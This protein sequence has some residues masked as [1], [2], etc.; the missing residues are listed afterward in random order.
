MSGSRGVVAADGTSYDRRMSG[1]ARRMTCLLPRLAKRG[2][3]P[4]LFVSRQTREVFRDL[5]G[6]RVVDLPVPAHPA[7]V[8][9]R[10][11]RAWMPDLVRSL[12]AGI[13]LT[14]IPP[15]PAEIPYLLTVHDLRVWDDPRAVGWGRRMWVLHTLPG[16]L[17][18]AAALATP[19]EAT[20]ARLR[21]RFP[22]CAP[23]VIPNGCDH[24]PA[25]QRRNGR[26]FFL[27]VGPWP[28]RKELGM[29]LAAHA[30]L[31][32]RPPL[33]LVGDPGRSLPAGVSA[34]APDDATL[35]GLYAGAAAT[36]CPSRMEGFG[37]PL[38]EALRL[39]CPVVA[40]DIPPHREVGGAVVRYFPPGAAAVLARQM[41]VVL[42]D[43]GPPGPRQRQADLFTWDRAAA[44]TDALLQ[45]IAAENPG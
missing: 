1:A 20:A 30:T 31:D 29:L 39:G 3:R 14:E 5:A 44:L 21:L 37:L 19:S 32:P 35:A 6:V 22:G 17:D 36:I 15:P 42:Q 4:I 23:V 16:A 13:L 10:L 41:E 40:S 9:N 28:R 2:W 24:L 8:R 11:A 12:G 45:R 26:A 38:A 18:R 34:L 25:Q 7:P 27:A 43:P 33:L